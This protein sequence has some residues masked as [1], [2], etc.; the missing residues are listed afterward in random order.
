M[1]IIHDHIRDVLGAVKAQSQTEK[2]PDMNQNYS[3]W[4]RADESPRIATVQPGLVVCHMGLYV[5]VEPR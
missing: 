2:T 1:L 5:L 4:S 3:R